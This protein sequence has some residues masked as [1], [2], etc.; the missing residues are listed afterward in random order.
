[1]SIYRGSGGAGT[2][3]DTAAIDEITALAAQVATNTEASATSANQSAASAT[4]SASSASSASTQASQALSAAGNAASSASQAAG[5]K[6]DAETAQLAAETAQAAAETAQTASEAAQAAAETAET[7]AGT[8]AS[9]AA[10]SATAASTS[11]S[12]AST[13]QTAA[14][15]AQTAA[16]AAQTST[17]ALFTQFGDQ[18]LGSKTSD[19]TLDN[20]GNALTEGDVYWNST[21]NVLKFYS[22]S[23]WAAPEDIASTAATNA[24]NSATAAAT[25]ATNAATSETN[26]QTYATAFLNSEAYN[27]TSTDTTNWDTAYG[28]GNHASAGYTSYTANQAVDTTSSPTFVTANVTTVDLGD[29]TVT[30]SAG[31]LYFAASGTNKMKLD[32]SGNLTVVG[33][34]TAGGTI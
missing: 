16:E 19:P 15:T 24:S 31:V 12:A 20:S 23:A 34:I 21:D 17:E 13:A 22:G 8:Q 7:N 5:Y 28:W 1:M 9:A 32:A 4:S 30:E 33:S 27:I 6:N 29:W 2:A 3:A 11:A 10:T 14:E 25:S 18:Y 26:A